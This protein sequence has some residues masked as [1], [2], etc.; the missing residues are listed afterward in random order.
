MVY[1]EAAKAKVSAKK[2]DASKGKE[3]AREYKNY[4]L[5]YSFVFLFL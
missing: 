3:L 1:E 5:L 4:R 2:P